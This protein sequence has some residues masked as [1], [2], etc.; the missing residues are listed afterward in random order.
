MTGMPRRATPRRSL[1]ARTMAAANDRASGRARRRAAE[2]S[3]R[4][5][6]QAW[7]RI[8]VRVWEAYNRDNIAI[9]AGGVSFN[10][11]LA[12]FPAMAAFVSLYGLVADVNTA[13]QHVAAIRVFL[14][15]DFG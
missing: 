7:R 10:I 6:L 3:V 8:A 14:P 1:L 15:A 12:I 2:A 11:V 4:P 9:I 13:A 5:S